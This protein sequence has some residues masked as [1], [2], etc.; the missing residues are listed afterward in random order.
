MNANRRALTHAEAILLS[1]GNY[2]CPPDT[3]P[4][5]DWVLS[6]GGVPVS[7]IPRD[8]AEFV[9]E[10]HAARQA[11]TEAERNNPANA[12]DIVAGW[13]AYFR[14]CREEAMAST[15]GLQPAGQQNATGRTR[16]WGEK[17]HTLPFV[18]NHIEAGNQ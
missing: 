12:P 13:T 7:P 8:G 3:R 16:W 4:L 1:Q 15:N 9:M 5:H 6:N 18:L 14:R 17:G 10:V 2:P 11:M